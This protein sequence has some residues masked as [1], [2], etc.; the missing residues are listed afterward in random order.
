GA[1]AMIDGGILETL[2]PD[3]VAG[4]HVASQLATGLVATRAG[5]AMSIA[6][7]IAARLHGQGGHGA[8][9]G[10]DGNVVLAAAALASRLDTVVAG[11]EYEEVACACSAGAIAAGTAANVVPR[12][13]LVRGSLRTFD[14]AQH[15][16][17]LGRLRALAEAIAAEYSVDVDLDLPAPV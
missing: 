17:A 13:A 11:M 8:L 5:V 9:R 14:E 12:E 1:A 2:R 7:W 16:T 10:A 3:R 4:L 15:A 6:Q